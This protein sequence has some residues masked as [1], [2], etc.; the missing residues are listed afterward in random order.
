VYDAEARVFLQADSVDRYRYAYV[1]GDPVNLSDPTG[2]EGIENADITLKYG[3]KSYQLRTNGFGYGS[4]VTRN[5]A[6]KIEKMEVVDPE[7]GIEGTAFKTA[8]IGL[9]QDIDKARNRGNELAEAAVRHGTRAQHPTMGPSPSPTR[10]RGGVALELGYKFELG[11]PVGILTK[12]A[13]QD[14][15]GAAALCQDGTLTYGVYTSSAHLFAVGE[16]VIGADPPQGT[17]SPE[18]FLGSFGAGAAFTKTDAGDMGTFRGQ[19]IATSV[20]TPFAVA[21]ESAQSLPKPGQ[22]ANNFLTGSV[23]KGWGLGA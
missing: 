8:L 6:G 23:G 5:A 9:A 19:T 4:V 20:S 21:A 15:V 18:V 13:V 16:D 10:P 7:H 14:N 12:T 17:T 2:L 11:P 22:L 3:G 1:W